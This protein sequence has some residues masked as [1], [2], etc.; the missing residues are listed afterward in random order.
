MYRLREKQILVG[1]FAILTTI[2]AHAVDYTWDTS[3]S[4]GI[5]GG[6]GTWRNGTGVTWTADGGATRVVWTN[7]VTDS[8]TF[9]GTSGGVVTVANTIQAG[10]VS[11]L[12]DGYS[13]VAT[14]ARSITVGG[15]LNISSGVT[16]VIG[17]NVT[18]TRGNL[19]TV[20]GSGHLGIDTGGALISS[21]NNISL[22]GTAPGS[23]AT[24]DVTGGALTAAANIFLADSD[25]GGNGTLNLNQG[26]VT[27]PELLRI[28]NSSSGVGTV[29][30]NGGLMTVRSVTK[31][32][33]SANFNFNGGTLRASGTSTSLMTGMTTA[34]V[35]EGGAIIDSNAFD[36]STDQSLSHGGMAAVDGGLKKIGTGTLTLGGASTYTGTTAISA[37]VLSIDN[38]GTTTARL[39]GTQAIAISVGGTLLLSES[40]ATASSDRINN[41][42]ELILQGGKFDLGG[43]SEGSAGVNGLGI[44]SVTA[45]SVLDFGLEGGANL[46]Q[47]SGLGA[48]VATTRLSVLNWTSGSDRLLFAG[49]DL[50]EFSDLY[51]QSDVSFNG[52]SGYSLVSFGNFYEVQA[53]PEPTS[54]ALMSIGAVGAILSFLRKRASRKPEV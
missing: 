44:L 28:S 17:A 23:T 27:A 36:V 11:F 47:F 12:T 5:Q 8:A 53:V 19:L 10:K 38:K 6:P 7:S 29:N 46:I 13:L 32:A 51:T 4:G 16:A 35:L 42:A 31:G 40:D 21:A 18:V 52:T 45:D 26:T 30:L 39:A 22:H 49:N 43:L 24:I 2:S 9:A 54:A 15:D 3:A 25:T 14:S 37:G 20:T 50:T 1:L 33:G 34:S 41:S 48:H